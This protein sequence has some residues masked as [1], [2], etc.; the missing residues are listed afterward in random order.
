MNAFLR[1]GMEECER[2]GSADSKLKSAQVGRGLVP[3]VLAWL[4]GYKT[5]HL[6]LCKQ[7]KKP[8]VMSL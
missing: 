1:R 2:Y 6:I 8:S 3:L 5:I 7:K 4:S